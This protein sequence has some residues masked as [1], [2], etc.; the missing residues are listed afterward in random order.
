M[1]KFK[2]GNGSKLHHRKEKR[3]IDE[4][5]S[6]HIAIRTF[7]GDLYK[8]VKDSNLVG[9]LNGHT[10]WRRAFDRN[11]KIDNDL[12]KERMGFI[13]R[14]SALPYNASPTIHPPLRNS[15]VPLKPAMAL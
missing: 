6:S 2:N 13:E 10:V 7:V 11:L 12:K 8:K 15:S 3:H 4:I 9:A 14:Y 5:T 1:W